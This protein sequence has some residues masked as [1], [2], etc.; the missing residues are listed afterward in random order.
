M[1][2]ARYGKA[3]CGRWC[4]PRENSPRPRAAIILCIN[5]GSGPKISIGMWMCHNFLTGFSL[6]RDCW[7]VCGLKDKHIR[8]QA[9]ISLVFVVIS[10]FDHENSLKVFIYGNCDFWVCT[11]RIH[12]DVCL[13][14]CGYAMFRNGELSDRLP[15]GKWLPEKPA[16]SIFHRR[17]FFNPPL[18]RAVK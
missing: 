2:C 18:V 8:S 12:R 10:Y 9:L 11:L 15:S 14:I 7:K 4:F 13:M 3:G 6:W 17:K 16:R 5:G 1:L